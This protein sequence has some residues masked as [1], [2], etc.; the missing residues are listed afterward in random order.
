[1]RPSSQPGVGSLR[2]VTA[3]HLTPSC[4]HHPCWCSCPLPGYPGPGLIPDILTLLLTPNTII[5]SLLLSQPPWHPHACWLLTSHPRQPFHAPNYDVPSDALTL[6]PVAFTPSPC[7]SNPPLQRS[8]SPPWPRPRSPSPR[9]GPGPA[10][11]QTRS[12]GTLWHLT[13]PPTPFQ[14]RSSGTPSHPTS[15][16]ISNKKKLKS[17]A[18]PCAPAALLVSHKWR[19]AHARC[20]PPLHRVIQ[21]GHP[22]RPADR[23][24]VG[25][26]RI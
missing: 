14:T 17:P 13:P 12:S 10:P 3:A 9:C 16:S 19:C 5:L 25:I 4:S 20:S 6:S 22:G 23:R 11:F 21:H 26:K 24:V 7:Y 15:N 8:R 18:P 1:M 2:A